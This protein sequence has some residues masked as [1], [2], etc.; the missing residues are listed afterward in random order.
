VPLGR[1]E[2]INLYHN[3]F[4][5]TDQSKQIQRKKRKYF[6]SGR[7][8]VVLIEIFGQPKRFIL[9]FTISKQILFEQ[10]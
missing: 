2:D 9:P 5:M 7:L 4:I 8:E 10:I 3:S 1:A 6:V